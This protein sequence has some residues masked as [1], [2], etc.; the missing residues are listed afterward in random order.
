[1]RALQSMYLRLPRFVLQ[2]FNLIQTT[3]INF[4]RFYIIMNN[5][6]AVYLHIEFEDCRQTYH[7]VRSNAI[8][9]TTTYV[10]QRWRHCLVL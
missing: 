9:R 3:L 6:Y 2:F 4:L 5:S 7:S 1:M 10:A 8:T